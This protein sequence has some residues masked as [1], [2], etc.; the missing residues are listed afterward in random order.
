MINRFGVSFLS[1]SRKSEAVAEEVMINKETG[2]IL[3]KGADGAFLSY[4]KFSRDNFFIDSFTQLA[5][6][7]NLLGKLY[8]IVPMT[9]LPMKITE[10][11][12]LLDA[13]AIL[14]DN[15]KIEK[16]LIGL[17]VDNLKIALSGECSINTNS[18][19]IDMSIVLADNATLSTQYTIN[20]SLSLE[21]NNMNIIIP[22]Y[23]VYDPGDVVDYTAYISS[24]KIN[25]SV[26]DSP[27]DN[28][29]YIVNSILANV[30]EV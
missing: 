18:P 9:E 30:K 20:T 19:L 28:L 14:T 25:R 2:E 26:S 11:V 17:D 29:R 10:N 27:S 21:E 22:E 8:S 3:L 5:Y 13:S 4:N 6:S 24:L 12:N 7:L 15:T 1:K 16:L 23:P